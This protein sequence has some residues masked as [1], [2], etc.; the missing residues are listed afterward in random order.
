MTFNRIRDRKINEEGQLQD[1]LQFH[2]AVKSERQPQI[3]LERNFSLSI[4]PLL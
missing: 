1:L 2:L 3:D 4:I